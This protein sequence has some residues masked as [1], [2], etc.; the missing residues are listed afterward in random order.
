[1]VWAIFL[2][3]NI[4]LSTSDQQAEEF[5]SRNEQIFAEKTNYWSTANLNA[6]HSEVN[7]NQLRFTEGDVLSRLEIPSIEVESHILSGVNLDIL[8]KGVAHYSQTALPG[9]EG[10][11][12]ITAHRSSFGSLFKEANELEMGDEVVVHLPTG[13]EVVYKITESFIVS[14]SDLWVIEDRGGST[15]TLITCD[16]VD[17]TA[18]RLI[19]YGEL[20]EAP[21]EEVEFIRDINSGTT[22]PITLELT[23]SNE[24]VNKTFAIT[25]I[26]VN[27]F[28]S[29]V[30]SI[31]FFLKTRNLIKI[32]F[33]GITLL[34]PL[35]YSLL[36]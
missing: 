17:S 11:F 2:G 4:F 30:A 28:L 18:E 15:I 29:A 12:V 13:G 35:A 32:T 27:L 34:Y 26:T 16:P 5:S 9:E 8:R 14:P 3:T 19:V 36:V 20:L 1:M 7:L 33:M 22:P 23:G 25:L 6:D 24:T 21:Q 10:N 31:I